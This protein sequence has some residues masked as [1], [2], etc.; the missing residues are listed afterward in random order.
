MWC[1]EGIWDVRGRSPVFWSI[2]FW[3]Y[4][5]G[6]D[7]PA[8]HWLFFFGFIYLNTFLHSIMNYYLSLINH[9]LQRSL[10]IWFLPP[11]EPTSSEDPLASLALSWA[12]VGAGL[13]PTQKS[14]FS[15][16]QFQELWLLSFLRWLQKGLLL[17]CSDYST[18]QQGHVDPDI[19]TSC[20][21]RSWV[22]ILHILCTEKSME[23]KSLTS[24]TIKNTTRNNHSK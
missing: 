12:G 16:C 6:S 15:L 23:A 13:P 8:T 22:C 2:T 19:L 7:N 4:S 3:G 5:S 24:F 9:L 17:S 14:F 20:T 1:I 21:L 10:D 11:A 18:W